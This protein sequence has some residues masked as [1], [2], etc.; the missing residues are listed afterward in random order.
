EVPTQTLCAES[1]N[2]V[3]TSLDGRPS[4]VEYR[5]HPLPDR[6]RTPL[7]VA[8]HSVPSAA[9]RMDATV[10]DASPSAVVNVVNTPSL[11]RLA[12]LLS[13]PAHTLPSR[14]RSTAYTLSWARPSAVVK[15][16]AT[17]VSP[18]ARRC[19]THTCC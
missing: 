3:L 19:G 18:S 16:R 4:A 12:P 8:N 6:A 9:S 1:S 17:N 13:V 15:G 10:F 7:G 2:R 11:N 5:R 14:A